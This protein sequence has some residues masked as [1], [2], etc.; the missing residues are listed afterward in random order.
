VTIVNRRNTI[1]FIWLR[2]LPTKVHFFL[3]TA[4]K[5]AKK[6]SGV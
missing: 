4:K 6:V 1:L 2:S 3:Q 5:N